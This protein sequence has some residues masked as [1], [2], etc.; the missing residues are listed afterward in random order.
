MAS[1]ESFS[2]RFGLS[3]NEVEIVKNAFNQEPGETLFHIINAFTA[4]GKTEG[5]T[6]TDIYK[7]EKAG[8]QILSMIKA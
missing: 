4:S 6:T 3:Q 7:F 8:G 2:K 1:I 5:L